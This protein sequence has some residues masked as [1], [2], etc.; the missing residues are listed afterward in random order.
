ML[1]G[2]AGAIVGGIVGHFAFLWIARQG[3]YALMVPGAAAGVGGGLFA[4]ERSVPRGIVAGVVGLLAGLF[5]EWRFAP[6]IADDSLAYFLAH[7][8]S[9]HS[10]TQLMI[11]AGGFFGY[12][13][14]VGRE[15]P[16]MP[17]SQNPPA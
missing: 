2:L 3:F 15:R 13:F 8:F 5:S 11:V 14:A 4:K 12:W 10:L 6:F 9:L 17:G 16:V 1:I 7:V